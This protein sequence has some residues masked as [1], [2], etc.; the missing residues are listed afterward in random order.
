VQTF[1]VKHAGNAARVMLRRASFPES[2]S[3]RYCARF[4]TSLLCAATLSA[5]TAPPSKADKVEVT[6]ARAEAEVGQTL[7][8]SAAASDA[9]G[10]RLDT[11]PT[12]WV[13]APFDSAAADDTGNVTF[14]H[15]GEIRVGAII[16]G[17]P[18][19]AVVTVKPVAPARIDIVDVTTPIVVGGG[20]PLAATVA[21]SDGTPLA[22]PAI[23]WSSD[24]PAV[25]TVDASG[26][27][28]GVAPGR[29]TIKAQSGAASGTS[30]L[31]VVRSN[32]TSI[33]IEPRTT[34]ARTGDVVRFTA[35]TAVDSGLAPAVRWSVTGAGATIDADGGFVA[36]H[37]GSHVVTAS[38]GDR[39]SIATVTVRPRDAARPLEV[40]GRT[41]LEEF[42]TMEQ[43]IVGKY[44]YVTSIIAGRLW[45]FDISNPA[46]PVKVDSVS[47][48][49]R[50]LND[51]STTP[52][53]KVAVVT[54]EGASNRK[55]GIVF[56]DTSDPAHPKILSEYTETVS[57]GVHSA[58]IYGHH[59][60]LTDDATGSLRVID[61]EDARKPKEVGRWQVENPLARVVTTEGGT[62]ATGG[63]YLHDVQVV[64]GLLYAGYWRDGLIILDVGKGIR[65]GSPSNPKLVSQLKFNYH[66]LYGPGWLAGAHAVFRYKQYVFVGDEVFPA[67]FD[68]ASRDVFPVKGIVHVVDVSDIAQP[69]Q[70]A[71]Y[72]VP[73]GGAHNMWVADDIMYMGYYNAG[74]RVV[75]VSG[76]LRGDLYRQGREIAKLWTGDPK[77]YRPNAP[78]CWG[79]QPHNGLIYFN[80]INSGVWITR[81]A[82][83]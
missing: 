19:F 68:I 18:G 41:P 79:A 65:G 40:V 61:F 56:L 74:A 14:Y 55:N 39:S 80:D 66:E 76:E 73:E 59:V 4:L 20:I 10:K 54:R 77:G 46:S 48:D 57:G 34:E 44:A 12:A 49:A 25:A 45:V 64:D 3:M 51:I 52:D 33:A 82:P 2:L 13:T 31:Q 30:A 7:K 23:K 50:A 69:R 38:V 21:A 1:V 43:W 22:G 29:A 53:G 17:K 60:Y 62:T 32:V 72:E 67:S 9:A 36:E 16:D 78:F 26:F 81:L 37:P 15:P 63:R 47:F 75:D 28:T 71:T 5:Q 58:Y 6:P 42:Q 83:K 8:F 27:V 24:S 11:K 35:K 70:V